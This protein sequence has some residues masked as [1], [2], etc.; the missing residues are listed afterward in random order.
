MPRTAAAHE[1][2]KTGGM[3]SPPATV[4]TG[5]PSPAAEARP[6]RFVRLF[7]AATSSVVATVISQV[8]LLVI[9][10]SGG[11]AVVASAVAFVAGAVPNFLLTRSWVWGR[12]GKPRVKTEVAPYLV[13]IA[14]GG[15]ASV[16][17]TT[18]TGHLLAPLALPGLLRVVL[19]DGAYVASYAMVFVF[20][21]TLLDRVVF[22]RDAVARDAGRTPATT[23][24][25]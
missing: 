11:S 2:G 9:L 4:E 21:F 19:L 14:L 12:Q 16:G 6:R 22:S 15:L 20:K 1:W 5:S 24:P 7:R 17:L 23:S 3:S 25:S 18:L 8:A 10:S 13:V